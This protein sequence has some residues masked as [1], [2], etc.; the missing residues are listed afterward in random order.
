MTETI[1]EYN[2]CCHHNQL[3]QDS[4]AAVRQHTCQTRA[5]RCALL[6]LAEYRS[7]NGRVATIPNARN[8]ATAVKQMLAQG[9]YRLGENVIEKR[10]P[11]CTEYKPF[12]RAYFGKRATAPMHLARECLICNVVRAQAYKARKAAA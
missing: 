1:W 10:C 9:Q 7:L 4:L 12:T 6:S 3:I 8:L 5:C 2:D 11:T